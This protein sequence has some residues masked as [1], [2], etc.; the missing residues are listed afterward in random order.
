MFM[1]QN[2]LLATFIPEVFMVI[3]FVLCICA[4]GFQ[5]NIST[6]EQPIIVNQISSLEYQHNSKSQ[7]STYYFQLTCEKPTEKPNLSPVFQVEKINCGY[8]YHFSASFSL[9][10][11]DFSRPPPFYHLEYIS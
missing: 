1:F 2:G 7:V 3:G 8:D 11:V 6:I 10:F 5:L 9:S 4:P